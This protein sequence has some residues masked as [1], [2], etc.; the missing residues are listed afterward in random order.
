MYE[1]FIV[2]LPSRARKPRPQT[3]GILLDKMC[4]S[5]GGLRMPIF[6]AKGNRRP[7]DLVQV[8]KFDSKAGVVVRYQIPIMM[9]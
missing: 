2:P 3:L 7:H 5:M 6:V 9:L 1:N 8:A 4:K